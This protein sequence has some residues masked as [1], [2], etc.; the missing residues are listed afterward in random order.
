MTEPTYKEKTWRW[1][2]IMGKR[3]SDLT[4]A[5]RDQL[6]EEIKKGPPIEPLPL[7]EKSAR[8]MSERERDEWLSE[9][10]KRWRR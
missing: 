3:A 1:A 10:K 8:E 2:D 6:F 4:P 7:P 9:H 5:Q